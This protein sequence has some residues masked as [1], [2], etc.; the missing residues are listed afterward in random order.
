VLISIAHAGPASTDSDGNVSVVDVALSPPVASSRRAPVGATLT[1]QEF[2]GNRKGAPL[3]RVTKTSLEFPAGTRNNGRLFAKCDLPDTPTE[4]GKKRCSRA[5]RIGTGTVEADAR[6]TIEEPLSG[7][8]VAYNG[9]LRRGNPTVILLADVQ[10]GG[11][12][13]TGELDFEMRGSTLV[14]LAP[15]EGTPEG[16]FVITGVDLSVGKTIR[17]RSG[18]RRVSASL[19]TTPRTCRKGIWRTRATQTFEGGA[20]LTAFDTSPCLPAR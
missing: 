3:P 13:V 9:E 15:P 5:S 11:G 1:F 8:I 17:V 14:S 2:F 12:K 16:L 10:V 4:L 7:K 6:P 20:T 18:G 19:I